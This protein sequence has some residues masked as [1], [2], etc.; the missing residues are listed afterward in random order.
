MDKRDILRT[1]TAE[2]GKSELYFQTHAAVTMRVRQALDDPNIS[3]TKV[4]QFIQ[5]EPVLSARLVAVANSVAFRGAFGKAL[6]DVRSAVMR[7]GFRNVRSLA[8]AFLVRQMGASAGKGQPQIKQMAA[9]LWEHTAHVTALAHMLARHVTHVDA[10]VALFGGIVHEVGGFYLLSRATDYP[11]LFEGEPAD[12]NE[13]DVLELQIELDRALLQALTIPEAA[14][15]AMEI[16][17]QGFLGMPPRTL[18]DTLLLAEDLAPVASPFHETKALC[19]TDAGEA[20]TGAE[21]SI[22]MIVGA[23]TL[24]AILKASAEE[25]DSLADVLQL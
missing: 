7:L 6:A 19:K 18:G 8:T 5:A 12:W 14:M 9:Q 10:E 4:A 16:F 15:E 1:I 22:E 25:V 13:E 24:S 2:I 20:V 11:D 23:E 3:V 17:W 21:A